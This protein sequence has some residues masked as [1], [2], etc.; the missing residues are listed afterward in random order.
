M[1]L[2]HQA[3]VGNESRMA[4]EE[5]LSF[6]S[7]VQILASSS[8]DALSPKVRKSFENRALLSLQLNTCTEHTWAA[9]GRTNP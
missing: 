1:L 5:Q 6:E 2:D 7:L 9:A 8:I 4:T 3:M